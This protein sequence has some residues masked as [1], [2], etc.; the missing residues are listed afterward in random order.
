MLLITEYD[1]RNSLLELLNEEEINVIGH[2]ILP[3]DEHISKSDKEYY[4][5]VGSVKQSILE[6]LTERSFD[7]GFPLRMEDYKKWN[8]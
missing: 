6:Y 8:F 1:F 7:I 4:C 3:D 2:G 5:N